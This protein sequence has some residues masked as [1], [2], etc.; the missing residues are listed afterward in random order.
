M[1]MEELPSESMHWPS[2]AFHR[3]GEFCWIKSKILRNHLLFSLLVLQ[4]GVSTAHQGI[5]RNKVIQRVSAFGNPAMQLWHLNNTSFYRRKRRCCS[6]SIYPAR[7]LDILTHGPI[8]PRTAEVIGIC[9]NNA[10]FCYTWSKKEMRP[11]FA[12]RLL[13]SGLDLQCMS[14]LQPLHIFYDRENW[15]ATPKQTL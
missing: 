2:P 1:G 7:I 4:V 6:E 15:V 13:L 14:Q 5:S 3:S 10:T 8:V 12:H 11:S 9:S